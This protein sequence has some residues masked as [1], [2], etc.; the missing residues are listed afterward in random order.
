MI[1]EREGVLDCFNEA[2]PSISDGGRGDHGV[3]DLNY[4]ADLFLKEIAWQVGFKHVEFLSTSS[5][6]QPACRQDVSQ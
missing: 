4:I 5:S 3:G 6:E 2:S 1:S